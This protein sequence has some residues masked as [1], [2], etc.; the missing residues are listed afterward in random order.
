MASDRFGTVLIV[1]DNPINLQL[2]AEGLKR[3]FNI[4]VAAH[5]QKAIEISLSDN[6]PDLILLDVMMP[7]IDGL[8]V[9][10]KL[11]ELAQTKDIPIIF[12]TAKN[13][14]ED[15]LE[16]LMLGAVDY[17]T[18][19][20]RMPI[21]K[22][23]I[24]THI[25]LKRKKDLLEKLASL[26]ALTELPNRRSFDLALQ[27]EWRRCSRTESF[28]GC[29]MIDIDFFKQFN[30]TYGHAAGDDCLRKVSDVLRDCLERPADIV[31]RYGG[32][33]FAALL[34]GTD[35]EGTTM[36]AEKM[37][38]SVHET[39]IFHEGSKVSEVVTI[40]AGAVSHIP[41]MEQ[42]SSHLMETADALLYQAKE[43]S[44]NL[45]VSQEGC[46]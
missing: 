14:M 6:P 16:G 43:Q 8:S 11:K 17:I 24:K 10:R 9:C 40:S 15:E 23:R 20:F 46:T 13:Q 39:G 26:D 38:A 37:R 18:K 41:R 28:I 30:D 3:D 4:K 5:G 45:V 29:I 31:A 19:P 32:E 42:T 7:E 27:R 21:V 34:P 22:A 36:V 12:V 1:D 44:R 35:F 33:E 25:E 2:L